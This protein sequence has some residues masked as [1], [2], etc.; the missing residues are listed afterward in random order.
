MKDLFKKG[1]SLGLGL[2]VVS[3]EQ[4]EKLVDELVKKG[5]LSKTESKEFMKEIL[6]K[7][8]EKQDILE[9]IVQDRVNKIL[10]DLNLVKKEEV[11]KLEERI[12]Y[13]EN[14]IKKQE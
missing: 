11:Q 14:E 1:L 12:A 5:D 3:K 6:K 8:E 10:S 2:A 13:L 7:G 9:K 4:A